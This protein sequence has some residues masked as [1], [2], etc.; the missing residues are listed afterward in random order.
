MLTIS[1]EEHGVVQV[2]GVR[3]TVAC[4]RSFFT[5]PPSDRLLHV[6]REGDQVIL[7]DIRTAAT[8]AEFF[9]GREAAPGE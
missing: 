8:A 1:I 3:V 7:T 9:A 2:D 5:D 4:L 6:R